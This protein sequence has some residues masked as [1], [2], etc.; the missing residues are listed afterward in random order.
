MHNPMS[1]AQMMRS[2]LSGSLRRESCGGQLQ[3]YLFTSM[4]LV[5]V[6]TVQ[7]SNTISYITMLL[8]QLV[9]CFRTQP[10]T[11]ECWGQL[12]RIG[13]Q[14]IRALHK[15]RLGCTLMSWKRMSSRRKQNRNLR[16]DVRNASITP[17]HHSP[18][19]LMVYLRRV[20]WNEL[21]RMIVLVNRWER[22]T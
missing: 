18:L 10:Q 20:I 15:Y 22:C 9:W 11:E 19:T 21:I 16:L 5:A 1:R 6:T 13:S 12:Q 2:L 8:S 14:Q 3:C 17:Q 7:R 4:V